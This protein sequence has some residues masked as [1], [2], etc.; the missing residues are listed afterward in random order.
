L[1]KK[2]VIP[3]LFKIKQSR[4]FLYLLLIN[5]LLA[6]F[7]CFSNGLPINYQFIAL[8][9]VVISASFYWLDYK[10]FQSYTISHN[11]VSGWQL[12]KI[13]N[14]Y[15]D[16]K[17]LPTTVLTAQFIVLHFR[18]HTGKKQAVL[19]VNDALEKQ[20]YRRLLVELKVSGLSTTT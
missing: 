14:N 16:I 7:A 9:I 20:D 2:F 6:T 8:F 11:K 4:L 3:Q 13:E 19:I 12:A 18:F 10:K 17:I 15:Q 5:H 1:L